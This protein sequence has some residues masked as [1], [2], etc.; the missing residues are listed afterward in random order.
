M[1]SIG[2]NWASVVS[3]TAAT[4]PGLAEHL[5]GRAR[6]MARAIEPEH[7]LKTTEAMFRMVWRAVRELYNNELGYDA[8]I[9]R[10]S[11]ILPQQLRRAWNAGM[12]VNGLDPMT[13]NR[14]EWEA[15]FQE[16]VVN[17]FTFVDGFARD[18]VTARQAQAGTAALRSRVEM[19]ANRYNECK[20][21]ATATTAEDNQRL[22]WIFGDTDHCTTCQA[23][24]GIV[25][26]AR[27]WRQAAGR[28]IFPKSKA[29]ECHGYRC[30]CRLQKTAKPLT[31]GGLPV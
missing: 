3:A 21:L 7:A 15:V 5:R 14:P 6:W 17:Q 26:T 12:R 18:I 19:W 20:D 2:I 27:E 29:L 8:F 31:A 1:P 16:F 4:M 25:A 23:L 11:D 10:M 13:D 24:N 28:G 9:D 22:E 30:Q